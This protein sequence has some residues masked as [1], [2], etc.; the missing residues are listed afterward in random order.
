MYKKDHVRIVLQTLRMSFYVIMYPIVQL[1]VKQ[2]KKFVLF[3]SDSR[4]DFSGNFAFVKDEI[5]KRGNYKIM[6]IFKK[7]LKKKRNIK[8]IFKLLY[9][10]AKCKYIFVDDFY[11]VVYPI[12]FKKSKRLIQLWHAMGAFKTVGYARMG[13]V[14]GPKGLTLT[15][16][17]YTDAI[18]SSEAIRGNYAEAFGISIDK[19]HA[20]GIPRTDIFFDE[21]YAANIKEKIYHKYP[22]LKDKKV[23]MFAPTFRGNGQ[24]TAH[25]NFDWLDLKKLKQQ[26]AKDYIC[27]IKLH[28]F[29][30]N[31]PDYDFDNDDFYLDLSKEREINDLLFITDILITDYSSVIFEYSF[32]EKPLIFYTPDYH[33]YVASRDFFYD[34]EKYNYGIR[35][36]DMDGLINALKRKDVKKDKVKKFKQFFCSACDG[37]ATKRV[38][39]YLLGEE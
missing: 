37:K 32:F 2:D 31:R 39:D 5:T 7:S 19:V 3:L 9:Y 13:K 14:G 26:F 29:I 20:L 11:P 36:N 18:V 22:Q 38:V 23:I 24:G 8:D 16:R 15:H 6:G 30:K 28:P 4:T 35:V 27:I 17:N 1:F 12:R 34:F 21:Q 25:Y 10:L 33:D